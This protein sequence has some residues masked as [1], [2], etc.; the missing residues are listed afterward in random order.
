MKVPTDNPVAA[1]YSGP[2]GYPAW[3]DAI[4]WERVVDMS[5][6]AKGA[7]AFER[8]EN[9]RDELAAQ[10]GGVLYYPAGVYE[11][12]AGPFDGPNGRGLMLKTGV[13][14]RGETP[15]GK[16]NAAR[17]G[18]LV[19][20]TKFVFGFQR[21]ENGVDIGDRLGITLQDAYIRKNV[22]RVKAVK[23]APPPKEEVVETPLPVHLNFPVQP[24]QF[25]AGAAAPLELTGK[26]YCRG[27]LAE[28][29]VKAK[30]TPQGD[31]LRLE[32]DVE[33][34]ALTKDNDVGAAHYV[35][36]LKRDGARLSG[37]YTGTSRERAVKGAAAGKFF[38]V[39]PETP[40]AWNL[41]GLCPAKGQ[42]IKD[43]HRVGIAWVHLDGA[44]VWFGPDVLWGRTWE[45]AGSWKSPFVKKE[46]AA[47][48]PDG[49]HPLDP[50]LGGGNLFEGAGEGR[51][52]FGCV[53]ENAAALNDMHTCGRPDTPEGFGP[54]GYYMDTFAPRIGAYGS[55]IFVA[56][57]FLPM[58][59]GRNFKYPQKTRHT[60]P[61]GN[62]QAGFGEVRDSVVLFD[63]N[64]CTGI[65]I[66]K[67][68]LGLVRG[69]SPSLE[70]DP[71]FLPGVVV[72]DN[73]VYSHGHKGFNVSGSWVSLINNHNERAFLRSGSDP[74]GIW[75]WELTLDGFLRTSPG[76]PG[77]ISDNLARAFDLGGMGVW[78]HR[79]F[80][81]NTGSSPGNDGEGILCQ[82]HGG[83]HWY[84]WGV[85]HNRHE[86]GEGTSSYIGGWA[87]AMQGALIAWNQT[88]GWVG[89]VGSNCADVACVANQ[90]ASVNGADKVLAQ[91]PGGPLKPPADVKAELS[92]G[93]VKITWTDAS[94]NE[95]GFRVDRRNAGGPWTAIAY[96]P[97]RIQGSE[98]NPQAWADFTAPPGQP[99]QYR[100]AAINAKDDDSGA[101]APTAQI[102]L[103]KPA[104]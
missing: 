29:P 73:W 51:L 61:A 41:I 18:K 83:T 26:A 89:L 71:Y 60:F 87:V 55:Q 47:R 19:L 103:P 32:A 48:V 30:F 33:L 46:W 45:L 42:R 93:A 37:A 81:N 5:A 69:S 77:T 91:D 98:R 25:A 67:D 36:E 62:H 2:E 101:A 65:D 44:A 50:F 12:S 68:M 104:R 28:H 56:N 4:R 88:A 84:S 20:P 102:V 43:V 59:E 96:R 97:P 49:T 8:F 82:S 17:D 57:N 38:S 39:R 70:S 27:S 94:D 21:R 90:C 99:L 31:T 16:P 13:V 78:V 52:V 86:K 10:G 92:G 9:A 63:Y 11:F 15:A 24:G 54:Q 66:N 64:K 14:I 6:Y 85:T 95:I 40:R 35:A 23:G 1:F 53:L 34:A 80:Y 22:R 79:N 74:Y 72:R 100:V 3:T 58:S 7:T 76:G 75:G